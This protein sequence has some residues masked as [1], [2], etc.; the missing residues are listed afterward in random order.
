MF[1]LLC[2]ILTMIIV[3]AIATPLWRERDA[4]APSAASYDLRIYH[5]Q[6]REVERDLERNVISP[7]EAER[8]RSEIGRRVLEADRR[9]TGKGT[10]RRGG[11][12]WTAILALAVL[13][14]GGIG[15]YL[16]LGAPTTSDLPLS[17]RIAAAKRSYDTRPSQA[18]AEAV[19]P[20]PEPRE[21]SQDYADLVARL[22]KAVA[23]GPGD[24]EGLTLLATH[25]MRLGNIQ[26]AREAQEQLV[27]L[28]GDDASGDE[29]MRL[30]ALMM[31]AAGGIITPEAEAILARALKKER[32]LPQGRY[33][34]G[35]LQLQN[36]RP[37]RAFPVWRDLLEEGPY[38]APW[39]APIRGSIQELAWLAGQPDYVPPEPDAQNIPAL[40]GPDADAMAAAEDMSPEE[41][42]Q[43]I[44]NMVTGLENRLAT[45]G[46]SPQEWARLIASLATLGQTD[47]AEAIWS[48][49]QERFGATP[50]AIAPIREAAEQAGLSE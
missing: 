32:E 44:E 3:A 13:V 14:A 38:D 15:I 30:S 20:R 24:A 48:E 19:A 4:E 7:E 31:E 2:A 40:P 9:L 17:E 46:G 45:E 29:L 12:A 16:Y 50:E 10:L 39:N 49:A 28:R 6:L 47:R 33:L 21:V 26:A 37:D 1:W 35:L 36:G 27:D 5:D 22:R 41:R 25:E 11:T 8:L 42:Q 23:A 43:M 34:F 18:E